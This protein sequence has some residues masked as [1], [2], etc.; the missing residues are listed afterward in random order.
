MAL[1][2]FRALSGESG[3]LAIQWW[4]GSRYRLAVGYV[5]ED[6]EAN[7]WYIVVDGK[8]TKDPNQE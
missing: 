5:G 7:V 4:D 3:L 6:C 1:S 2:R 8:L